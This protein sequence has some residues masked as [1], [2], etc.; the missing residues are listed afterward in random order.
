M[1]NNA[2]R[3]LTVLQCSCICLC[4]MAEGEKEWRQP[5]AVL[6]RM[7][8]SLSQHLHTHAQHQWRL[9]AIGVLGHMVRSA[10]MW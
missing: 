2:L 8:S 5:P 6:I 3:V 9:Y 4:R 10:N 1:H 7:H